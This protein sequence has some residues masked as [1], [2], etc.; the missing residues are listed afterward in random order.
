MRPRRHRDV[1]GSLLQ[2]E[3]GG[4]SFTGQISYNEVYEGDDDMPQPTTDVQV[5]RIGECQ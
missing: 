4:E 3:N 5:K 2:P 1:M